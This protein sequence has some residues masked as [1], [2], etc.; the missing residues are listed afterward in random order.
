[1][2]I[3]YIICF[4]IKTEKNNYFASTLKSQALQSWNWV[5]VL[6]MGLSKSSDLGI[7]L[8]ETHLNIGPTSLATFKKICVKILEILY[9]Q[10][11]G[12]LKKFFIKAKRV[13]KFC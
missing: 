4:F 10:P 8:Q 2:E 12:N 5:L 9:Q 11:E 13:D 1:M 6:I 3:E 7:L